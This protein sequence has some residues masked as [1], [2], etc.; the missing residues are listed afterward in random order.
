VGRATA[1]LGQKMASRLSKCFQ[2]I[3]HLFLMMKIL[4]FLCVILSCSCVIGLDL[5]ASKSDLIKSIKT[6]SL[7]SLNI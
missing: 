2:L 6:S 3:S 5:N 1:K 4:K 7:I